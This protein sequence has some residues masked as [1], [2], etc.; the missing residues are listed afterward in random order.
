MSEHSDEPSTSTGITK[1]TN[2]NKVKD[3]DPELDI[4]NEKFNPLKALYSKEIKI[5]SKKLIKF[6][7]TSQF[8]VALKKIGNIFEIIPR[9]VS[10]TKNENKETTT[11]ANLSTNKYLA[12]VSSRRFLP[13]QCK[14]LLNTFI[15]RGIF[16]IYKLFLI[17]LYFYSPCSRS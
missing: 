8:E 7:N 3:I 17:K 4:T 13:H 5:P 2:K 14:L 15:M 9:T 10:H 16:K 11:S 1:K 6:D 12:E